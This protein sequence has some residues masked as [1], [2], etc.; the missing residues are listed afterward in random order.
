MPYEFK[1]ERRVEFAETDMAGIL[2]F[3]DFFRYMEA[4]EH[5]FLRSFG[6]SIH[7]GEGVA[8]WVRTQAECTFRKPV[9][10]EDIVEMHLIVREKHSKSI[11]YGFIFRKDGDEIARGSLTVVCVTKDEDGRIRAM[12]MPE[13]I[14]VNVTEAP[15]ELWE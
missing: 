9:R 10:F 12:N 11:T 15:P 14:D 1:M 7:S 5:A 3:S 8:G 4:T 2:H 6:E 13:C